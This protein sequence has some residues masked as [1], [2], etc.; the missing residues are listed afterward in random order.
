MKLS[1][2]LLLATQTTIALS[3][4]HIASPSPDDEHGVL[5]KATPK[6]TNNLVARACWNGA[7]YGCSKGYCWTKCQTGGKWCWLATQ[8]G[9]GP[10]LTCSSDSQ[11]ASGIQT[12]GSACGKGNCDACGCSC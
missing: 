2:L 5:N 4:A 10:W 7:Y 12:R 8:D 1:T 6:D 3:A 9:N 11:C